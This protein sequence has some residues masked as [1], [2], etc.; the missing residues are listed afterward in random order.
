MPERIGQAGQAGF[1][2][3]AVLGSPIAHSQSPVLHR[4][5]YDVL[6]LDWSYEAIEVGDGEL[7][8]FVA[9]RDASWRGLSLTMPLKRDILPLLA[10]RTELVDQAG[11]A[12]TALFT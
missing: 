6:G 4:A 11:S 7:A 9:G 1:A 2:R 8:P 3:L 10:S 5:A 12:N